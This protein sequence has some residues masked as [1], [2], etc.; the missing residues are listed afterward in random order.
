MNYHYKIRLSVEHLN[1]K[2]SFHPIIALLA[3]IFAIW[4]LKMND[5]PTAPQLIS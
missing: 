4:I 2:F 1:F 3:Y 5:Y